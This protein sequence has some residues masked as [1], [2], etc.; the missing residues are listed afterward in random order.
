MIGM[1]RDRV[2]KSFC[3]A[4][5]FVQILNECNVLLAELDCVSVEIKIII[6]P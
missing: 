2:A 4:S 3:P 1:A 6:N 5:A